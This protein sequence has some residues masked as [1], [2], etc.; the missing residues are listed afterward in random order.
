MVLWLKACTDMEQNSITQRDSHSQ[1]SDPS[2]VAGYL[3]PDYAHSLEEF[4]QPRLLRGC[5][6]WILERSIANTPLRDGMGCYPLFCCQ[7]W[8]QVQTDLAHIQASE[9][10]V[11]LAVV[12]DPFGTYNRADLEQAFHD[13][14]QTFKA[15]FVVDL[16][17]APLSSISSH[18]RRYARKALREV[19][20]ELC[21][22]PI[23]LLDDWIALYENLIERHDIEGVQAFSP[24]TFA[25]QLRVPGIVA[26]RALHQGET[27]SMLLWFVQKGVGYYHL[28]ASSDQGYELQ[29][30]FGLFWT[31]IEYFANQGL[32][33]LNLGAGAGTEA[34]S[35]DGLSR[36]K[37]GWA[38]ETRTAY[39]CGRIFDRASYEMLKQAR[40]IETTSYFPAYRQGEFE[41]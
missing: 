39:F 18:H 37:R 31:A 26:L 9:E 3:H 14:V 1:D 40:G 6:G 30:S 41:S 5:Q 13:R 28:G 32:R 2:Q 15:H 17:N 24:D 20:V 38:Q 35:N 4:G 7:D 12:T 19:E 25:K 16:H 33:W 23:L 21:P 27:V 36:F 29:A 22:D 10:L 34:D 8:S 11:S